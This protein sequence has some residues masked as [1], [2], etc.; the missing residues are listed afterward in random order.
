VTHDV[1]RF[2]VF[3]RASQVLLRSP[4]PGESLQCPSPPLIRGLSNR[5]GLAL[6]R[7][8]RRDHPARPV[9]FRTGGEPPFTQPRGFRARFAK[10]SGHRPHLA[11]N[12]NRCIR[13][14]TG[15]VWHEMKG[16]GFAGMIFF[17]VDDVRSG[18]ASEAVAAQRRPKHSSPWPAKVTLM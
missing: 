3:C 16:R 6:G 10:S 4:L 14:G 1:P 17:G 15:E 13:G 8:R 11:G 12:A 5:R 7:Q 2:S 9:H 18:F